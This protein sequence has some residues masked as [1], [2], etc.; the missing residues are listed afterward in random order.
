MLFLKYFLTYLKSSII[1]KYFI[2]FLFIDLVSAQSLKLVNTD[3]QTI[4]IKKAKFKLLNTYNIFYLNDNK[5]LLDNVD[6][7]SKLAEKGLLD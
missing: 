6:Y 1:T 5:Y 4:I 7:K 2:L 3:G